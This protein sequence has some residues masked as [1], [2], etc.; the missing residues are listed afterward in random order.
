[1]NKFQK[2]RPLKRREKKSNEKK[3]GRTRP[4]MHFKKINLKKKKNEDT[5][6][7]ANYHAFVIINFV[8]KLRCNQRIKILP[9]VLFLYYTERLTRL[10]M[11]HFSSN[12]TKCPSLAFDINLSSPAISV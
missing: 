7:N 8:T 11:F 12:S 9:L 5:N 6:K 10:K 4:K 3:K 1:M 2:R